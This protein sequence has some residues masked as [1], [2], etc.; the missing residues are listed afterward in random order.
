[1]RTACWCDC[2]I[3]ERHLLFTGAT[4]VQP[5]WLPRLV[6]NLCVFSKPLT[7][8]EPFYDP[9][10]DIQGRPSIATG[11]V[12]I[13]ENLKRPT[14]QTHRATLMFC[15]ERW[16]TML[17]DISFWQA[18]MGVEGFGVV[19]PEKSTAISIFCTIYSW[20][21]GLCC[22]HVV[23]PGPLRTDVL[24]GK[25]TLGQVF[26]SLAKFIPFLK[27]KP[28]IFNRPWTKVSSRL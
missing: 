6:P 19:L 8:P 11:A 27:N 21:Q 13:N 24:N 28:N 18:T 16:C 2:T 14:E 25:V 17:D 26:P 10:V 1:M 7:T 4:V 20:W 23:S 3:V 15:V 9:K 5:E 12:P 22:C